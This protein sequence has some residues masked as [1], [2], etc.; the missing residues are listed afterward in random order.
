MT[1]AFIIH[2]LSLVSKHVLW[3]Y[4]YYHKTVKRI[5]NQL[6]ATFFLEEYI[7]YLEIV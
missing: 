6:I 5:N 1:K 3:F 2:L 4:P 7:K